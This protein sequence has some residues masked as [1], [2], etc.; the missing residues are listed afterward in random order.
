MVNSPSRARLTRG[1]YAEKSKKRAF[2][3][4]HGETLHECP[5]CFM[6]VSKRGT[7]LVNHR[8]GSTHLYSYPC[9]GSGEEVA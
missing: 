4:R 1:R 3:Q 2:F 7:Q 8:V 5:R 9:M 6:L